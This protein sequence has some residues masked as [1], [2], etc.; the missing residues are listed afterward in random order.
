MTNDSVKGSNAR[1]SLETGRVERGESSNQEFRS[2]SANFT[3]YPS[4]TS[5]ILV[6][7]SI[8]FTYFLITIKELYCFICFRLPCK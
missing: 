7:T 8:N 2:V 1:N 6:M 4:A 5:F 3:V